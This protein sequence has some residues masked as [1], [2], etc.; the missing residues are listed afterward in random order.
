MQD[1]LV[2]DP[3]RHRPRG[4]DRPQPAVPQRRRPAP[5]HRRASSTP[6]RSR[7]GR[8]TARSTSR[9]PRTRSSSPPGRGRPGRRASSSTTSASSTPTA[10][11]NMEK[12]PRTMVVVGAGVI[13][14]EYASMFAAL[15]TR[16]TVVEARD[17]MLEFCDSEVVDALRFHLRD[18]SVSFRFGEMVERGRDRPERHGDHAAQRQADRRRHRHVLGR[19]AGR[20][21]RARPRPRPG[22]TP[23]TAAGSRSTRASARRVQHIYAV[24]DVI[25]F[26]ALAATSMEQGRLAAYDAFG[27]PAHS[28]RQHQ[29]IGIYT[30]P[31]ISYCGATEDELTEV[32]GAVRGRHLALPR[33]GARPDRRRHVRDAQAARVTPRPASCSACTSSGPTRPSSS[34]SARP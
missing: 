33:A 23:T 12:V 31:E 14:I 20:H 3:A 24:G 25:G 19:P 27:E 10:S 16:V 9:S 28:L 15:G 6:T 11:S 13:G 22:W 2:A 30:I 7:C 34:T 17:R 21:R 32:V 1:L 4:R 8:T 18:L 29:P 26:P 5:R